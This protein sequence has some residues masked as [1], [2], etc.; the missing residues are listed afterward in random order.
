MNEVRVTNKDDRITGRLYDQPRE[1]DTHPSL[2]ALSVS[3]SLL[4]YS[5][6]PYF[7]AFFLL[8]EF[9]LCN[10][11]LIVVRR[12]NAPCY[13]DISPSQFSSS[14]SPEWEISKISPVGS[15]HRLSRHT[16]QSF[17]LLSV[18]SFFT[19]HNATHSFSSHTHALSFLDSLP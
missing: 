6:R 11:S 15:Y 14:V 4:S 19:L 9:S 7:V 3:P 5:L 16:Q 12:N 8:G 2:N 18:L 10:A 1:G 17:C 13:L